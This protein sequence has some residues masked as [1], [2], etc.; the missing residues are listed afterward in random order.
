MVAAFHPRQPSFSLYDN[1]LSFAE[2]ESNDHSRILP[3]FYDFQY[4]NPAN[5]LTQ[6]ASIPENFHQTPNNNDNTTGLGFPFITPI[7]RP[8]SDESQKSIQNN[9]NNSGNTMKEPTNYMLL[10]QTSNQSLLSTQMDDIESLSTQ[11]QQQ[12]QY[13]HTM[14]DEL[15]HLKI[16]YQLE[17]LAVAFYNTAAGGGGNA[18]GTGGGGGVGN[19]GGGASLQVPK[20]PLNVSS[21]VFVLFVKSCA[22]VCESVCVYVGCVCAGVGLWVT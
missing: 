4:N 8:I 3:F 11:H 21:F 13:Q 1:E 22:F 6:V 5:S 18:S 14:I 2:S 19:G 17:L 12:Q 16:Y 7:N 15:M 9:N 20:T 10:K